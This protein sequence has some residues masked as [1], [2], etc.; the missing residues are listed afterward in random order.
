MNVTYGNTD[1]GLRDDKGNVI[2]DHFDVVFNIKQVA[3]LLKKTVVQYRKLQSIDVDLLRKD[4]QSS[5][6][7]NDT[8]GS[9]DA[10]SER[11]LSE[12]SEL[13]NIL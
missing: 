9:M 1:I 11:Y 3:P 10:L 12:P 2:H 6:Y 7:L 5:E 4:I 8:T 13:I